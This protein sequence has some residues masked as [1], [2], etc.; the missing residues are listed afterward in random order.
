L[1]LYEIRKYT[2]RANAE[3]VSFVEAV[4]LYCAYFLILDT[5]YVTEI[6]II[7][8]VSKQRKSFCC[9]EEI[10][11]LRWVPVTRAWRVFGSRIEGRPPAM[12]VS[13]EYTE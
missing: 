1:E 9:R 12:V 11:H 7:N 8:F 13:C 5:W 3:L 10:T 6:A 4:S 2:R